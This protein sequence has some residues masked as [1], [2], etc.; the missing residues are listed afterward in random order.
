MEVWKDIEGYEGL[1]Q[2]SNQGRVKNIKRNKFLSQSQGRYCS[3]TLSGN[4]KK[5]YPLIH[6][7][8]GKAFIPNPE[9]YPLVMHSDNNPLNNNVS[10]LKWGT[11]SDN[12]KHAY[13]S[14]NQEYSRK[15]N[16]NRMKELHKM[17][18]KMLIN[19]A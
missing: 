2:I 16:S 15:Y 9:N 13:L 1:Y 12:N 17:K 4:C 5:E 11:H 8:V 18:D 19:Y 6:R 7:L 14:G 3:V 10:N